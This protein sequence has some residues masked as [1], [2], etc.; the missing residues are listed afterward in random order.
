MVGALVL[1]AAVLVVLSPTFGRATPSGAYRPPLPPDALTNG[2]YPLPGGVKLDFPYQVRH[3]GDVNGERHLVLQY[4]LID[5]D[6]AVTALTKSFGAAGFHTPVDDVLGSISTD[7][8]PDA[9][10]V[11]LEKQGIGTI[12][13]LVYPLSPLKKDQIVRGTIDLY[14]PSEP[15]QSS[16]AVCSDVT[17]TKRFPSD[18]ESHDVGVPGGIH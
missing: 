17:S 5:R 10:P 4:D 2:C 12:Q 11:V 13:A 7:G 3:D 16:A 8:H 15:A 18:Q 14:L 6:A 9:V 1:V